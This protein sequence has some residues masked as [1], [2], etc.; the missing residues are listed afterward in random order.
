MTP[1]TPPILLI[2]GKALLLVAVMFCVDVA[3]AVYTRATTAGDPKKAAHWAALIILLSVINTVTV[4]G[5]PRYVLFSMIGA[6]LG[7][8]MAVDRKW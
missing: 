1:D 7:T 3:Y 5:D 8:Y 2:A 4:V 6:W